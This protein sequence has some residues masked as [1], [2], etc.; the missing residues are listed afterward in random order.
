MDTKVVITVQ[1]RQV[2]NFKWANS[3]V[4]LQH[5]YR[6]AA[7][8]TWHER[9]M[10]CSPQIQLFS[11][12]SSDSFYE[13]NANRFHILTTPSIYISIFV[14]YR[15]KWCISP[16]FLHI[17]GR[18]LTLFQCYREGRTMNQAFLPG[19]PGQ[20]PYANWAILMVIANLNQSVIWPQPVFSEQIPKHWS[21]ISYHWLIS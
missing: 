9:H 5:F 15:F 13:L 3:Q 8:L 20:H 2:M 17:V 1:S 19:T 6:D 7:K 4:L 16:L 18:I 10:N 12:E 11:C 14:L 21:V